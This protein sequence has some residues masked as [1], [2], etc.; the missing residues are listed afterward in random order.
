M[1]FQLKLDEPLAEGVRRIVKDQIDKALDE[2]TG[3]SEESPEEVVHGARKR[4][5]KVRAVL[6]LARP[7]LS[8]KLYARENARFRDAGRPLSEVRDAEILVE[9]FDGL[10]GRLGDSGHPEA[11]EAI[12]SVLA[13]R[14]RA[15]CQ[16]VLHE[17]KALAEATATVLEARSGLKRWKLGGA[18][19]PIVEAGLERI[20]RKGCRAFQAASDDPTDEHLHEWRKRV[21]DLWYALDILSPLQPEF[22]Q[23]RGAEA[24]K[25][26][27]ALGDDHD[28]AVLS[29]MITDP[30]ARFGDES[31][32]EAIL[33]LIDRRRGELRQEAF[34][35]GREVYARK[36]KAF[37]ASLAG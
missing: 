11:V 5:K 33:P 8:G 4:F 15:A 19:W 30:E 21:K 14:K 31:K 32:V 2:L 6:R 29:Q 16:K 10:I 34:A 7:G 26:A 28:L 25:L 17:E 9:A 24:H 12:R 35:L 36:P 22:V 23:E 3:L 18:G 37:V 1:G 13:D 20:Y 27:D